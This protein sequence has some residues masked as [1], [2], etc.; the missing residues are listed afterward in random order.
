MENDT[1]TNAMGFADTISA[2]TG[3]D[4]ISD[5]AGNDAISVTPPADVGSLVSSQLTALDATN[6]APLP[7]EPQKVMVPEAVQLCVSINAPD[8]SR[9]VLTLDASGTRVT[10]DKSLCECVRDAALKLRPTCAAVIEW[11]DDEVKTAYGL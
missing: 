1:I 4:T 7:P 5:S 2:G 10:T 6:P 9:H 11:V 8:G 3:N